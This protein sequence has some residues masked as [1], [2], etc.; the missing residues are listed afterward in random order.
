MTEPLAGARLFDTAIGPVGVA[1]DERGL[2]AVQLPEASREATARRLA[3]RT[4]DLSEVPA[5]SGTALPAPV[6]S[7][8]DAMTRLL[9]GEPVDLQ[10]VALD[11]ERVPEFDRRVYEIT[12]T[13]PPGATLTYGVIALRLGQPGAAREVGQALGRNPWPLVVPCHRVV[14]AGGKLGGFSAPQGTITKRR[15]LEIEGALAETLPLFDLS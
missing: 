1:W 4:G 13:I 5:D 7:A 14:A 15:L 12:R 8:I 10:D 9:A 6:R 3:R 2:V 11:L